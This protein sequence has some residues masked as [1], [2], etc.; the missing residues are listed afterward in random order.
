MTGNQ[1]IKRRFTVEMTAAD[2][3][4]RPIERL[5]SGQKGRIV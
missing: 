4:A 3:A 1:P 5:S 2:L